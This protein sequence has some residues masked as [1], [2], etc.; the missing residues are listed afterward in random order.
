M[1][2][3][4]AAKR[5]T[6]TALAALVF[7]SGILWL[8]IKPLWPPLTVTVAQIA[9]NPVSWFVVAMFAIAILALQPAR[10]AVRPTAP[11][12]A[13]ETPVAAKKIETA[14]EPKKV[15]PPRELVDTTPAYLFSLRRQ[16]NMSR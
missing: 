2:A 4:T 8:H 3:E 5:A 11:V 7:F 6:F 13:P 14:P 1:R 10:Q 12:R 9:T 15:P 16:E